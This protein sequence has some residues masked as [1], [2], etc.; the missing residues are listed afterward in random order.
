MRDS[1]PAPTTKSVCGSKF[2]R[3]M[4]KACGVKFISKERKRM[5]A[6]FRCTA[7]EMAAFKAGTN[8]KGEEKKKSAVW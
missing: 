4:S 8:L 3:R 6:K 7:K 2:C 5:W 1:L